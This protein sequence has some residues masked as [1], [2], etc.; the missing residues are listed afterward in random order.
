MF[1]VVT[2]NL[3]TYTS[4]SILCSGLAW[5]GWNCWPMVVEM[6]RIKR[7]VPTTLAPLAPP[8]ITCFVTAPSRTLGHLHSTFRG[9]YSQPHCAS[10]GLTSH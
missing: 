10:L 9:R 8:A 7:V 2:Q 1:L 6:V 3:M 4:P 5:N